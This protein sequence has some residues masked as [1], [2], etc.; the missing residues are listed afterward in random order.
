MN[1]IL[2]LKIFIS[3]ERKRDETTMDSTDPTKKRKKK[4]TKRERE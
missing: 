2:F 3:Q 1:K 4:N